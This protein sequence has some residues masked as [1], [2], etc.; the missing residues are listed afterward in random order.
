VIIKPAIAGSPAHLRQFC[1]THAVDAVFSSVFETAIG[2]WT[3]LQ[4]AAE[5]GNRNRAVGYGTAHWFEYD[6]QDFDT[7]WQTL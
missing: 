3:G 1:Q 7:L 6:P 4:L 2:R 5:L